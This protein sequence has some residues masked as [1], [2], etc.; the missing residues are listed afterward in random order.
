MQMDGDTPEAQRLRRRMIHTQLM[1]RDINDT[2]TLAALE[3]VP[4][5]LFAPFPSLEEAYADNPHHIDCQQTISQPYMVA[6]MTQALDIH[7]R[8]RVL[9]VGTGSGYQTAVLCELTPHVF[10]I[11][12][13]PE[14]ALRAKA[15]LNRLGYQAQVAVRDGTNGMP[16]EAPFDR[17]IVTAAAKD[18]PEA[19]LAQLSLLSGV[20]LIPVGLPND[21]QELFKIIR[22]GPDDY[23]KISLGEVRFVPLVTDPH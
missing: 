15:L 22:T 23:Q 16:K 8:H 1:S 6:C 12:R 20:L 5:H 11:E 17:I 14:L 21:T 3:R 18:I 7:P 2:R 10:S 9:E 4:R 13:H 19:M